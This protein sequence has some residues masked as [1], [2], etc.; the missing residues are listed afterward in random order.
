MSRFHSG[1]VP[2]QRVLSAKGVISPRG[3]EAGGAAGRN[4]QAAALRDEGVEVTQDAMGELKVDLTQYGWF[5]RQLPS[6]AIE[7]D[8]GDDGDVQVKEEDSD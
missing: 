2:W 6:D 8:E 1:T 4:R 7:G 3:A 5:P